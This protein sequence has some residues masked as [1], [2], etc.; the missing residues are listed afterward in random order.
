MRSLSPS[1]LLTVAVFALSVGLLVV[2][3]SMNQDVERRRSEEQVLVS[4][5][6]YS[7]AAADPELR[8]PQ[9]AS[10]VAQRGVSRAVPAEASVS[11]SSIA[12]NTAQTVPA[13][14]PEVAPRPAAS[15]D[16]PKHEVPDNHR[17]YVVLSTFREPANALKDLERL[18][19]KG[20]KNAF[21][22]T[23]DEGRYY[24]VIGD[25]YATEQSARFLVRQSIDKHGLTPYVYH[26][27]D[28][29]ASK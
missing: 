19:R 24:S 15:V 20:F 22:G 26:K 16:I 27:Q 11:A 21:I 6:I 29:E 8:D 17:Y 4:N 9:R 2:K 5:H 3:R 10:R 14:P 13:T 28:D 7:P 12:T 25:T 23:F 18:Q 1:T